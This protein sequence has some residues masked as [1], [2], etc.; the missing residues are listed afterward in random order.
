M[1]R[2]LGTDLQDH[3]TVKDAQSAMRHASIRTTA[4]VYMQPIEKNVVKAVNSRTRKILSGW[5]RPA[6]NDAGTMVP[7]ARRLKVRRESDGVESNLSQV[8]PSE[9]GEVSVSA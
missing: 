3:G 6:L 4:D 1:R 2:T 7:K 8:V 9:E 5:A